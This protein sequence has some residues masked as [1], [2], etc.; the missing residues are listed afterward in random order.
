MN[1]QATLVALTLFPICSLQAQQP[2]PRNDW[3][4]FDF[5]VG[6]WTWTGGGK[7][8]QGNGM[9]TFRPDTLELAR[10]P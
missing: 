3:K 10:I 2:P 4:D 1:W 7:P 8:G 6:E 5:L 9:S